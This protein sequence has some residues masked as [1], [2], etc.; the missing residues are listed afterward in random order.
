MVKFRVRSVKKDEF[1]VCWGL[2]GFFMGV[3]FLR[4]VVGMFYFIWL[5][6]FDDIS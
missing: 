2:W 4:F 3:L 5:L 6:G 1:I